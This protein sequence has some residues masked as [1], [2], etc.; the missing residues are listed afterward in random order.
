MTIEQQPPK[1]LF[2]YL[3]QKLKLS[4]IGQSLNS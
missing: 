3:A 4:R 1:K 2:N